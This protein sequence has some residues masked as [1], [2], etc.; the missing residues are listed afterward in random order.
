MDQPDKQT[1]E[2][3][4]ETAR[5]ILGQIDREHGLSPR[6]SDGPVIDPQVLLKDIDLS[7]SGMLVRDLISR[8][9]NPPAA[10]SCDTRAQSP[11]VANLKDTCDLDVKA[12]YDKV[13]NST[14]KI[15]NH[16]LEAI[17][18]GFYACSTDGKSCAIVTNYHVAR[19]GPVDKTMVIESNK[20][21]FLG[22]A[23]PLHSA[24]NDL[25]L[26]KPLFPNPSEL[27]LKPVQFGNPVA[28]GD[29]V[30]SVCYPTSRLQIPVVT[31]GKVIDP[32]MQV[33]VNDGSPG[34]SPPSI[35]TDQAI[36]GGCSG[37]ADFDQAGNFVG[38]TRANGAEGA[39]VIKQE[40]VQDL[41]D[42]Y[43]KRAN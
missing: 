12:V 21:L 42:D 29:S 32:N 39:V 4:Y 20:Q 43:E 8:I 30:L 15:L 25:A 7:E 11:L 10:N 34:L 41:L 17:G 22:Q 40:H 28:K 19:L 18:S 13:S 26:I 2:Q 33:R 5:R 24:S 3:E 14:F 31:A 27:N 35:I 16:S 23:V 9:A 36:Y 1:L 6:V 37:G 38:L